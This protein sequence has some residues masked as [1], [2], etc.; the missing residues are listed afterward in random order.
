MILFYLQLALV[1]WLSHCLILFWRQGHCISCVAII[2]A[3]LDRDCATRGDSWAS[4]FNKKR[5]NERLVWSI[6]VVRWCHLVTQYEMTHV[7]DSHVV[8][9]WNKNVKYLT[10]WRNVSTLWKIPKH[11]KGKFME[12][13]YCMS[14]KQKISN[15]NSTY[16]LRVFIA[17]LHRIYLF[18]DLHL[19]MAAMII[20][21]S[22]RSYGEPVS[23]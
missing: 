16:I 2:C 17:T 15:N 3:G 13:G 22:T 9:G 20:V 10:S 14:L 7:G 18:L 5:K 4:P 12:M 21:N 8:M 19:F 1:R 23:E 6:K 11:L